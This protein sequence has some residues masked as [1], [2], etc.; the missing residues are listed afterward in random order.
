MNSICMLKLHLQQAWLLAQKKTQH[1]MCS[2][3]ARWQAHIYVSINS[4]ETKMY[5]YVYM[6]ENLSRQSMYCKVYNQHIYIGRTVQILQ[7]S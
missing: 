2:T 7:V 4:Y 1:A 6:N 5:L 3:M